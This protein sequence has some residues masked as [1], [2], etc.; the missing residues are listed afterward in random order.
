MITTIT[1]T[2]NINYL[3][4]LYGM[5]IPDDDEWIAKYGNHVIANRYVLQSYFYNADMNISGSI[6][7][8]TLR[9]S[10]LAIKW[11][12]DISGFKHIHSDIKVKCDDVCELLS[13]NLSIYN[14]ELN[15]LLGKTRNAYRNLLKSFGTKSFKR[16]V[17]RYWSYTMKSLFGVF[18]KQSYGQIWLYNSAIDHKTFQF[19]TDTPLDTIPVIGTGRYK[20][21]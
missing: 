5:D 21:L 2:K 11:F 12:L 3:S 17:I 16:T 7:N 4:T 10:M 8:P 6:I 20:P 18:I 9:D 15:R 1:R 19:P 14:P 13:N